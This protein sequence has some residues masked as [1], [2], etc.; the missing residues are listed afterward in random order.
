MATLGPSWAVLAPFRAILG[1]ILGHLRGILAASCDH[2]G[3]SVR[4]L[5]K[6]PYE[7]DDVMMPLLLLMA[8]AALAMSLLALVAAVVAAMVVA[9]LATLVLWMVP[10]LSLIHI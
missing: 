6:F 9:T 7:V 4:G 5:S 3:P 1:V 2:L 8:L 10:V